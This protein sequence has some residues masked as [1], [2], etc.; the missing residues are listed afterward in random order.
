MSHHFENML[1]KIRENQSYTNIFQNIINVFS[2]YV[3]CHHFIGDEAWHWGILQ[4]LPPGKN[5]LNS[6]N[7][8]DIIENYDIVQ[9]QLKFFGHFVKNILPRLN[10]KIVLITSQFEFIS[11]DRSEETDFVLNHPN[12]VLWITTNPMYPPSDKYI[13]FPCGLSQ[14][15][16]TVY[17]HLL[18]ENEKSSEKETELAHMHVSNTNPCR[19]LLPTAPKYSEQDFYN[20]IRK[21]KF[22]ISPIGDRDDC[23]RHYECIG[24]KT[25]PISNVGEY[26]K[27]I[28]Q[29]NM[30]YCPIEEM[31]K[32]IQTNHVN[33]EYKPP[34]QNLI[35]FQY[36]KDKIYGLIH[37]K[38]LC[39]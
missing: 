14:F 7:N 6:T 15:N 8:L 35:S 34:D 11:F 31:I 19:A 33:Y 26:Y 37:Q 25:I 9:C 1:D 20:N 21:A 10:K 32:A 39:Q 28:F 13:P 27:P 22:M 2:P 17:A 16:L 18:L 4:H 30:H 5:D 24:L 3:L 23:Y 12:I 29:E 36:H 38:R